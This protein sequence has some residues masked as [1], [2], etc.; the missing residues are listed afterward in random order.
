M[1]SPMDRDEYRRYVS[2]QIAQLESAASVGRA[3]IRQFE[4]LA[5][6]IYQCMQ[7]QSVLI[8]SN[9]VGVDRSGAN[10]DDGTVILAGLV[11]SIVRRTDLG[12]DV[13]LSAGV[14]VNALTRGLPSDD[15]RARFD[16]IEAPSICAIGGLE[17]VKLVRLMTV[18]IAPGPRVQAIRPFISDTCGGW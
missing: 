17:S 9:F 8:A 13:P 7:E 18:T 3:D 16:E 15:R 14:M 1:T 2:A 4:L 5:S 11:G 12:T 10:E 6:V